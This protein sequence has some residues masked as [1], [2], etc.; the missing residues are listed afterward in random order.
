MQQIPHCQR[1]GDQL[2]DDRSYCR[3]HHAPAE[4][5]NEDGVQND[6]QRRTRKGGDHGKPGAAIRADDRVHGLPEHIKGHAQRDIEEIFL[7]VVI[8][9]S[10]HRSA[11]HGQ[12]GV[13]KNQIE[14]CQHD[15][16]DQTH[17]HRVAYAAL[18]LGDLVLSKADADEGAAAITDHD[19]D[20][21]RHHR[22]GENDRIGGVAIRAKIAGVCNKDL[23]HDIIQRTHQQRNNARDRVFLHQLADALRA[24]KLIG[25]FHGI[26]LYLSI[27]GQTKTTGSPHATGF[28]HE[29]YSLYEII[30]ACLSGICKGSFAQE[31][32]W[33]FCAD[34]TRK[35]L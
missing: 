9:L 35:T 28:T 31:L 6:V 25:V 17:D 29:C 21:Q 22:Q 16:A 8:G 26:H 20:C 23:V 24:E 10:V 27:L 13:R 2:T 14:H 19:C 11:E 30:I 15:A 1:C 34:C 33:A 7:R 12:N 4:A 5:E 18:C 3:A 32:Y